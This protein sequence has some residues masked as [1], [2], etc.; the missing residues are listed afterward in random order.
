V[1]LGTARI[2]ILSERRCVGV[3]KV[4]L[5]VLLLSFLV[6]GGVAVALPLECE[7]AVETGKLADWLWCGVI[8]VIRGFQQDSGDGIPVGWQ[9]GV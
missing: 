4:I 1:R 2:E 5:V 6:P 8:L 9:Y 3:R 7:Y